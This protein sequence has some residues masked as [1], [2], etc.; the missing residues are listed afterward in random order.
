MSDDGLFAMEEP[1]ELERE[2]TLV[3]WKVLIVDDEEAVHR[4]TKLV[5][6]PLSFQDKKLELVSAYSGKEALN[7]LQEHKDIA[8]ILL[9]VVMETDDAGLKVAKAI[10]EELENRMVRII[11]RTGQPGHAPEQEVIINYEINDYKS[12]SELTSHALFTAVIAA[13][14]SFND[15]LSIEQSRQGLMQLVRTS[16]TFFCFH[17]LQTFS[18]ALLSLMAIE[19]PL[20]SADHHLESGVV[21]FQDEEM[22]VI[23]D[24]KGAFSNKERQLLNDVLTDSEYQQVARAFDQQ[25]NIFEDDH[26]AFYIP[27]ERYSFAIF[28]RD[29]G[30]V[31]DWEQQLTEIFCT[32]L[33]I[34]NENVHLVYELETLNAALENKVNKR[35]KELQHAKM[36][37]EQANQAKSR[38]LAAMSHEIR[39]PM[40]AILGY[41]QLLNQDES[42]NEDEHTMVQSIETAGNH[43]MM[44]LN[45]ILDL[46]KIEAGAMELN[47]TDF[48]LRQLIADMDVVFKG[49]CEGK[50]LQFIVESNLDEI[51]PVRGDQSKL[52]QIIINLLG[53]AVKFTDQGQIH[54]SV[55]KQNGY[56][57]RI[58]I[59]DSGPGIP[60]DV[61]PTLFQDFR[62]GDAG[63][64]KGGTGLG[65]SIARRL[66]RMMEGDL[67]ARSEPGCGAV[68][69]A[70]VQLLEAQDFVAPVK[71]EHMQVKGLVA[72]QQVN[73]LIVDDVKDNRSILRRMLAKIGASYE[74]A[75]N[76]QQALDLL[77]K[78]SFDIVFM[79][80]LMPVLRGD[81]A[82]V[83]ILELYGDK[84]PPCIAISAYS[85]T[86][87][88]ESLLDLGFKQFIAKP[89]KYSAILDCL[90]SQLSVEFEY[91]DVNNETAGTATSADGGFDPTVVA[92]P[93]G[94]H[95]RLS[96]A[97]SRNRITDLRNL[98]KELESQGGEC[99]ALAQHFGRML[100]KYDCKGILVSL[101]EMTNV[102]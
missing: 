60:P 27:S 63:E 36:E 74:E 102:T 92:I 68:F 101:E 57:Y 78:Q 44:L 76:G 23:T 11:L 83:K 45:D 54:L 64:Q 79:D 38:F 25:K 55:E 50:G 77:A 7:L 18:S 100:S 4:I 29:Y 48:D 61:L 69:T 8:L 62:Q 94:L 90:E 96:H 9:D 52:Q 84:A 31:D 72:G 20:C 40:N 15:L 95:E 97:A 65:L 42:L 21:V 67:T 91:M 19:M 98:V 73:V 24:G 46:S 12:K 5:L 14:R 30:P 41:S 87:N 70:E 22:L 86:T 34:A 17:S 56:F 89:F 43:L 71:G 75:E 3:P 32:N 81:E 85:L 16:S 37:A 49:R 93:Q 39:T 59:A 58:S 80:I 35:T 1:E 66:S 99:M 88:A 47:E 2:A 10:R 13:L 53:N 6:K 51:H 33:A 82:M 26:A 28:W